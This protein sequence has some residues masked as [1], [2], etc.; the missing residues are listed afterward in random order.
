[1]TTVIFRVV[2]L[3]TTGL[4]PPEAIIEIGWS[5]V[6]WD[7]DERV[8][9]VTAPQS[10][11]FSTDRPITPENRAIHHISA[12]ELVDKPVCTDAALTEI[13]AADTPFA[14][15]AANANFEQQWLTE[16]AIGP[17]RWICTVKAAARL[18]PDAESHSN[19]AIRYRMD[20][21]L[22]DEMAMPPHRAGPDAYVT[23]NILANMLRGTP[24][25]DL[26]AWTKEPKFLPR[27]P[28]GKWKGSVWA[29][30]DQSY[31]EWILR[32]P[33]MDADVQHAARL[34]VDRRAV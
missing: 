7:T 28:M 16:A 14:L 18:Y 9:S 13:L 6:Y 33:D 21:D 23:G 19:Q 30:V 15:V 26:I 10:F 31:L 4:A 29:D 20:L 25:R 11:L 17:A 8:A 12:G 2:D 34:E 32:T 27:C 3:E 24:V 22:P 5:D 1:M